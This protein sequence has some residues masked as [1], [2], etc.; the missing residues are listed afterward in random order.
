MY[1]FNY[2]NYLY[3]IIFWSSKCKSLIFLDLNRANF[4][5][6]CTHYLINDI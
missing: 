3:A 5:I 6:L 2:Y 1:K 4:S